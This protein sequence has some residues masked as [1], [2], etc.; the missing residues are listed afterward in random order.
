MLGEQGT[1]KFS[2]IYVYIYSFFFSIYS[3]KFLLIYQRSH[4]YQKKKK[5]VRIIYFILLMDIWSLCICF[6]LK[7]KIYLNCLYFLNTV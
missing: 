6:N 2:S 7:I 4:F 1:T 3:S 5:K